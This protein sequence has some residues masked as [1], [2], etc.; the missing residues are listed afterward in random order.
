MLCGVSFNNGV[1][2]CSSFRNAVQRQQPTNNHG[3]SRNLSIVHHRAINIPE[4]PNP[5]DPN[6][7]DNPVESD[8]E[9]HEPPDFLS[10]PLKISPKPIWKVVFVLGHVLIIYL[11]LA[12]W[13]SCR[14]SIFRR[15]LGWL[16]GADQKAQFFVRSIVEWAISTLVVFALSKD[17]IKNDFWSIVLVFLLTMQ[18][19][20]MINILVG[21]GLFDCIGYAIV[22][23]FGLLTAITLVKHIP[24]WAAPLVTTVLKFGK[25]GLQESR[26]RG[27]FD[28]MQIR[29]IALL[30]RMGFQGFS[31]D[32]TVV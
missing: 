23:Y 28:V 4:D 3:L 17:N 19:L 16:V 15:C 10:I 7:D 18:R 9:D 26:A 32:K 25:K 5:D 2:V 24:P 12:A 8:D 14:I 21:F 11:S 27:Y 30:Q 13:L 1:V 31:F 6:P 29:C 20:P 22:I